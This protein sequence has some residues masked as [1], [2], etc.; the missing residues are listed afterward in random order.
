MKD[1]LILTFAAALALTAYGCISGSSE[2]T[3]NVGGKYKFVTEAV[4][5]SCKEK[6]T[7]IVINMTPLPARE[8]TV[9]V[10]RDGGAIVLN[11]TDFVWNLIN[12]R[13][14]QASATQTGTTMEGTVDDN[15]VFSAQTTDT[16]TNTGSAGPVEITQ[17]Y[18]GKFTDTG[19]SGSYTVLMTLLNHNT[20]CNGSAGFTGDKLN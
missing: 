4:N 19:V 8:F 1:K 14:D 10:T 20:E 5:L 13:M 6:T 12:L 18:Q 3:L 9:D 7:G 15:G 16:W 2:T 17:K 11:S